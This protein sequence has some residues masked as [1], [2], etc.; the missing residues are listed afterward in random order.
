MVRKYHMSKSCT[1]KQCG[2]DLCFQDMF[3]LPLFESLDI[4]KG[5]VG[6]QCPKCGH[7]ES[8]STNN[9]DEL[10]AKSNFFVSRVLWR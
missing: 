2:A 1:C 9:D 8:E 6:I 7:I 3:F 4:F 10:A 5:R